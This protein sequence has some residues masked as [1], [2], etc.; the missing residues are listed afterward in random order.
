MAKLMYMDIPLLD[1]TEKEGKVD[2][3]TSISEPKLLPFFLLK[4]ISPERLDRWRS[5]RRIPDRREEIEEIKKRREKLFTQKNYASLMDPYWIKYRYEKWKDVNFFTRIYSPIIGD[6]TFKPYMAEDITFKPDLSPDLST[7]G[8][9]RKC[10][11]QYNGKTDS[12]LIKAGSVKYHHEPLSEVLSSVILEKLDI[13]RSVKYDLTVEGTEM[14]SKCKNF[15][16]QG[17]ELITA[18]DFYFDKKREKDETVYE[19]LVEMC[20]ESNIEHAKS[21]IDKMVFVDELLGNTDRNLSNIGFIR[22]IKTGEIKPAPLY[23]N[24]TAFFGEDNIKHSRLVF[25]ETDK[26][27]NRVLKDANIK[28]LLN[29]KSYED[30]IA[31]YPGIDR[32]KADAVA[33]HIEQDFDNLWKGKKK[34]RAVELENER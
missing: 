25:K 24:G 19:H 30:I 15:V 1:F 27:V 9:L 7:I 22:D 5:K 26:I 31:N 33:S 17:E 8:V 4:N 13:V 21:F 28:A 16:K 2:S 11:R 20:K 34:M 32:E 18:A 14:C 12:Y 6:L 3:I 10:W 23:D 29:D